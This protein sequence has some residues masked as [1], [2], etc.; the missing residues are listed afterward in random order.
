MRILIAGFLGAIAMFIWTS[1]AHMAT[2][3]ANT[4]FSHVSDEAPLLAEMQKSIG[5]KGGLYFVP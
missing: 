2:P 4:G 5:T 3:L 1:I